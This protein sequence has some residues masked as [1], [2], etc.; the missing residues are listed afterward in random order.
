MQNNQQQPEDNKPPSLLQ[1]FASVMAAFFGV[2][3]SKNK[4]RDFKNGNFKVFIAVGFIMTALF[5]ATVIGIVN[6][7][8]S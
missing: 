2:Q 4:E 3:S 1:V 5:L 6:W 7:V 8:I